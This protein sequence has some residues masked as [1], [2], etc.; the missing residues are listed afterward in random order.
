MLL[1]VNNKFAL[2]CLIGLYKYIKQ[3]C[4]S[5]FIA[6]PSVVFERKIFGIEALVSSDL[7]IS[8]FK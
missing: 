6:L 3:N 7:K 2:Y 1:V 5:N 8:E 4:I